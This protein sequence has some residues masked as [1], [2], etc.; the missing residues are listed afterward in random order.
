MHPSI[1]QVVVH[2]HHGPATVV[3][4]L[5]RTLRDTTHRYLQ[6]E[7]VDS[8]MVVSVPV[9]A[10][11]DIGL[12]PLSD[13]AGVDEIVAVLSAPSDEMPDVWSRRF[14]ENQ[15][16][17]RS[18]DHLVQAEVVRDLTRRLA[19]R[20]LSMGEKQQLTEATEPLLT[21]IALALDIDRGRAQEVVDAAIDG[22]GSTRDLLR[23][24]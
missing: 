17:L 23:A 3:D 14:K 21:E 8:D 18:T 24:S 5:E 16:R 10:L 22:Q 1:G 7:V 13:A 11:D 2:P 6:L 19:E 20:G 12:R 9:A 15:E 4:V